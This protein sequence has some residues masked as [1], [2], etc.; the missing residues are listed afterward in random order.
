MSRYLECRNFPEPHA[1]SQPPRF[2]TADSI[3]PLA[4][5]PLRQISIRSA[6]WQQL[7]QWDE[8]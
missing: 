6:A 3:S 1:A 2:N 4:A 7:G 5:A 8:L